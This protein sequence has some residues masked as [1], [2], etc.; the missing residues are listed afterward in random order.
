[1]ACAVTGALVQPATQHDGSLTSLSIPEGTRFYFPSSVTMPNGLPTLAQMVFEAVQTYG[2]YIMDTSGGVNGYAEHEQPWLNY[3]DS[4]YPISLYGSPNYEVLS[5]LPWSQMVAVTPMSATAI[6]A[7]S[8]VPS[9]PTLSANQ[10]TSGSGQITLNWTTPSSAGSSSITG[11]GIWY[12]TSS[13]GQLPVVQATVSGSTTLTDTLTLTSGTTYYF[14]VCAESAVGV[15]VA[16]DEI[17][18]TAP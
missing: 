18:I 15:G 1:M 11:Y 7:G 16:S 13:N 3:Q 9:A 6:V 4:Y 5:S 8:T 12:G 14:K 2:I 17:S 10:G